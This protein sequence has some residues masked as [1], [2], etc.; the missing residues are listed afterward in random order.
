MVIHQFAL[1]KALDIVDTYR[2]VIT[3]GNGRFHAL[4]H[5][6]DA[7]LF[8][9]AD[10]GIDCAESRLDGVDNIDGIKRHNTAVTLFHLYGFC[11]CRFPDYGLFGYKLVHIN[12][13]LLSVISL[14]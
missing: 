12:L 6:L 10:F 13:S 5:L 3:A 4:C 11:Y 9:R 14:T 2:P 1:Y 8:F 7:A